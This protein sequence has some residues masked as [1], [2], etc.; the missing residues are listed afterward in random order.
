MIESKETIYG[1]CPIHWDIKELIN[2][3]KLI[4]DGSHFSPKPQ[5]FGKMMCSVKDMRYNR[6]DF[7][8]VKYINQNDY[9]KLV[10]QGC[11]PLLNDL[12]IS[13]DGANCLDILFINKQ[14]E[15]FVLLSS[16]AIIRLLDTVFPEFIRYFLL[17]PQVQFILR[18]NYISGSAIP[19]VVLKD[20]KKV[21][22]LLPPL[23]EQRTIASVLS[24]LDDKIDLLYRQNKTLEAM[25][26]TLFRQ[27]FVEEADEEWKEGKVLDYCTHHKIGVK[28]QDF[29]TKSYSHYSIPAFDSNMKP[30]NE[31]GSEI[32][33]NKYT[34]VPN[35][36]LF[37]KLNP[38]KDKRIW[39]L[40]DQLDENSVCSTEF[41][42]ILPN[43]RKYLFFLYSW[44]SIPQNYNEITSGV[45]GTSGSHQRIEP[46]DIFNF[47][48]PHIDDSYIESFNVATEPIFIKMNKNRIQIH[49]LE[50]LR[51]TLLPKLMSGDIRLAI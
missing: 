1:S 32:Q 30:K 14:K 8:D 44:L 37:S 33:S 21:D 49:T 23:S 11:K 5:V 51:D 13:K 16:I 34:V 26:E 18:T 2:I 25:A 28:P 10:D 43:S 4:T 17:S 31:N 12:L 46:A 38:N 41:Q 20:F 15:D 42:V 39:L 9:D 29:P 35:C 40:L 47:S 24:S 3:S 48:C 7:S 50:K 36:L 27:W 45:G 6:F 19:R 22:I